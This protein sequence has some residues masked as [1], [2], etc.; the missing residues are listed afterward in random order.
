[1]PPAV[2]GADFDLLAAGTATSGWHDYGL[3]AWAGSGCTVRHAARTA[4]FDPDPGGFSGVEPAS[5]PAHVPA[6][7]AEH[8]ADGGAGVGSV[9]AAVAQCSDWQSPADS[10][11]HPAG[12][13]QCVAVALA[14][15]LP[16]RRA[17]SSQRQ[18]GLAGALHL[19]S[20]S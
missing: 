17:P 9:G 16:A 10:G 7:A 11:V 18:L 6:V 20:P 3:G 13:G 8:G 1:R 12:R 2:G 4:C 5:A 15:R 14:V 19:L